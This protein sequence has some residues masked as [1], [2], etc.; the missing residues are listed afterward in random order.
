[1]LNSI[2]DRDMVLEKILEQLGRVVQC[3]STAI[4]LVNNGDLVI[5]EALGKARE[6]LGRRIDMA[7]ADPVVSIIRHKIPHII[8]NVDL[9]P[10][11]TRWPGDAGRRI[12]SWMGPPLLFCEQVI[13]GG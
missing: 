3:D 10:A 11:W 9:D 4:F 5:V 12:K 7:D 8:P 2:L 6:F 13:G 1:M